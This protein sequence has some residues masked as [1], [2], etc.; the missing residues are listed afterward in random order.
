MKR[1][2]VFL[3]AIRALPEEVRKILAVFSFIITAIVVFL[4]SG[5]LIV[6]HLNSLGAEK[7]IPLTTES[8]KEQVKENPPENQEQAAL[9]PA[10]GVAE[11]FRALGLGAFAKDGLSTLTGGLEYAWRYVYDPLK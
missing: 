7:L 4:G 9:T 5:M 2:N 1:L 10:E 3:E 8:P 6:G 11:S